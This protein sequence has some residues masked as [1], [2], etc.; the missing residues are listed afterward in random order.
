MFPL[1]S[2]FFVMQV[3]PAEKKIT[4]SNENIERELVI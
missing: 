4:H 3:E 1:K 2:S